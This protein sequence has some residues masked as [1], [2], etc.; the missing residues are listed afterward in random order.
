MQGERPTGEIRLMDGRT[1]YAN[2]SPVSAGEA[3]VI[4]WVATMQDVSHFK[5]LNE[6]KN[7]FVNAVSHD[8]RSP[9]SGIL[10]ATH[11]VPQV[12]PI[13]DQQQELL[14]TVEERVRNMSALIDDLLD[15]GKIEAGIDI[16]MEPT[17]VTPILVETLN[18]F[19]PQAQ[20][21]FIQ[22]NSQL[23]KELPL[24]IANTT[25]L[26]QVLNNL[27]GNAIKYTPN[28]GQVTVKAFRHEDEIRVQVTDTGMGIPAAD[29]PHIFDKFYRVRGDHVA[30]IKG[31]GLG[32]A[33][34]KGIVEKHQGRVWLESVFG[35]GSTFTVAL[36]V[37]TDIDF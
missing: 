15:V 36:P 5:E 8:L 3:G 2:L 30:T 16:E 10:I 14:T 18:A 37:Y 35:E 23:E 12:G 9:L 31:T 25:R 28:H 26:R 19:A 29:Q 6:L 20:D 24:T 4:G 21:K 17:P 13:T 1:F 27:V 11:L 33:L 32:L 34:V 22:L 7:D